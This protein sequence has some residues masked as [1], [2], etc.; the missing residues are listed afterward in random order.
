MKDSY[1]V[2]NNNNSG[3]S[4]RLQ[5]KSV[6]V[7]LY[8]LYT[9]IYMCVRIYMNIYICICLYILVYICEQIGCM[10]LANKGETQL[11]VVADMQWKRNLVPALGDWQWLHLKRDSCP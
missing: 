3:K 2:N 4:L 9:C 8:V 10:W 6:P 1:F 7:L 11:H 5:W